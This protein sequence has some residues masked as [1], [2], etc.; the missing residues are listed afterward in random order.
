MT[1]PT[2]PLPD[3]AT[4]PADRCRNCAAPLPQPVPPHC[5]QCGQETRLRAPTLPELAQQFGGAYISTE[6]A[7]WRSLKLLLMRP[8]ELTRLYWAGRRK[9]YVLPLRLYLTISLLVLLVLRLATQ[10]TLE[11]PLPA[12]LPAPERMNF[13]VTLLVAEVGLRQGRYVCTGLPRWVCERIRTRFDVRPEAVKQQMFRFTDRFVSNLGLALFALLPCFALLLKLAYW[14]R[15]LRYTEHL[16]FGLHVHAF[17]F[18]V[19]AATLLPLGGVEDL[20]LLAA[21]VYLALALRRSYGGGWAATV[22]RAALV[23]TAYLVVVLVALSA[24]ALAVLMV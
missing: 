18:L 23:S 4:L 10:A 11:G 16:V 24:G 1:P 22:L 12:A 8:G 17:G 19:L 9:H 6:G 7:L 15:P 2:A 20:V 13:T 5:P 3:P 21:P 14:G